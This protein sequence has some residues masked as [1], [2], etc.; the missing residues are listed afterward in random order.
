M[1][2]RIK[3]QAPSLLVRKSEPGDGG[4]G[5]GDE[6]GVE[7]EGKVRR[8]T[9]LDVDDGQDQLAVLVLNDRVLDQ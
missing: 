5:Q 2:E 8:A 3:V 1:Q 7:A 4:V 9:L 6:E